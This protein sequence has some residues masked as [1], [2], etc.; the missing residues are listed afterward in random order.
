M[1]SCYTLSMG[2]R[3]AI[4]IDE[5]LL[6]EIKE[7][8]N[9]LNVS[10]SKFFAI[11]AQSYIAKLRNRAMVEKLNAVYSDGSD[12]ENEDFLSDAEREFN[13]AVQGDPC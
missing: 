10:R 6:D 5:I 3:I 8:S 9:Q 7:Y 12:K 2:S 4:S 1:I 13:N 11:A